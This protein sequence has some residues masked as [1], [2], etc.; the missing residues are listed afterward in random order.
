MISDDEYTFTVTVQPKGMPVAGEPIDLT[1]E[2]SVGVASIS[3]ETQ[4]VIAIAVILVGSL[5]ITYLF[6]RSRA[7]NMMLSESLNVELDD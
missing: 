2:S 1:V 7:E 4:M 6:A 3:S 5:A